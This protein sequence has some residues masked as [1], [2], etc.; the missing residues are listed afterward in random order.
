MHF[1][2]A[3]FYWFISV[4]PPSNPDIPCGHCIS[5]PLKVFRA[6]YNVLLV[7]LEWAPG[8]KVGR[9]YYDCSL[10]YRANLLRLRVSIYVE[11][12]RYKRPNR[13]RTISR[14]HY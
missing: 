13:I 4:E 3:S 14:P 1:S 11:I 5:C 8:L 12:E 6:H 2:E 10:K 7:D 9:F